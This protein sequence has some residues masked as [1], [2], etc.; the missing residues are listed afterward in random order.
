MSAAGQSRPTASRLG[1][2]GLSVSSPKA[3]LSPALTPEVFEPRLAQ[4]R[5]ARRVLDGAVAEP[6]LNCPRVVPLVGQGIAA[7]VPQHVDVNFEREA[8]ALADPF[9]QAINSIGG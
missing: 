2:T 7:G 8:A 3:D 9:D 5:V 1:G 4:F 6:V